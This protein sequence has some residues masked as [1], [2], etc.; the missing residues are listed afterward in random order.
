MD[1]I[2][3]NAATAKPERLSIMIINQLILRLSI[4]GLVISGTN[5]GQCHSPS[6]IPDLE[7]IFTERYIPALKQAKT[8]TRLLHIS[9]VNWQ[10]Y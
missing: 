9:L 1:K 3:S 7:S 4:G 6:L 2:R 10:N 8:E 5:Q